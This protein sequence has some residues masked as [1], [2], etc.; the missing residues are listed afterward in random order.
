M[1]LP[2]RNAR[3][4][5]RALMAA[6][7][8]GS[9]LTPRASMLESG[10]FSTWGASNASPAPCLM[11]RAGWYSYHAWLAATF[12][13]CAGVARIAGDDLLT[14]IAVPREF[15]IVPHGHERPTRTRILQIGVEEEAAVER[16][17]VL[18][19]DREVEVLQLPARRIAHG[20]GQLAAAIHAVWHVLGIA[21]D[22]VDEIAKVQH[23]AQLLCA[24]AARVLVDHAPVGIHRAVGDVLAAGE[25]E[26]HRAIIVRHGRGERAADA[27]HVSG[28]VD[29]AIP[30]LA[31]GAEARRKKAARPVGGRAHLNIAARDHVR[32]G[33]VAGDFDHQPM[34]ARARIR[35][36]ARPQDHAV[37]RGIAGRHALRIEITP[38]RALGGRRVR[39]TLDPRR[40]PR[41]GPPRAPAKIGAWSVRSSCHSALPPALKNA[42][43]PYIDYRYN[44]SGWIGKS[45]RYLTSAPYSPSGG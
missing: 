22:L 38:L 15:V 21:D 30:V 19:I 1:F 20:A 40:A 31:R 45:R 32:E 2:N 27:A 16:A 25:G 18:E 5:R 8:F 36:A 7:L 33:F 34:R 44:E 12:R 42:G 4:I 29:E 35:R 10:L 39:A 6:R 9:W 26:A 24:R 23:E 37:R 14:L 41:Q 28:L 3:S 17:I 11:T 13:V 43:R